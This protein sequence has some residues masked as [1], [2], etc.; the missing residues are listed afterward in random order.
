LPVIAAWTERNVINRLIGILVLLGRD[1]DGIRLLEVEG[2]RSGRTARTPL[3]VLELKT[4]RYVVS[5][6][7][8]SEWTRN[9]R[10][11][12]EAR[13]VFGR[14]VEEVH[15]TEITGDAK[16]PVI[17]AYRRAASR[18][19]T[20]RRLARPSADV[21]IFRLDRAEPALPPVVS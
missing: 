10:H 4:G 6:H 7:G 3:K 18:D 17:D 13:I 1:I 9:L 20:R 2:R 12:H 5:L 15:A 19:E 16:N 21:P 14:K 11:T 8:Q